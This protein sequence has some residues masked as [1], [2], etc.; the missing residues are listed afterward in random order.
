MGFIRDKVDLASVYN[1]QRRAAQAGG[2]RHIAK[3]PGPPR[4]SDRFP[5]AKSGRR[6][7]SRSRR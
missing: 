1:D 6:R 3:E 2:P 7:S 4:G 5:S